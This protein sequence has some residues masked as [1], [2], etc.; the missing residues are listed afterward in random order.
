M[1]EG[2]RKPNRVTRKKN[3]GFGQYIYPGRWNA[4]AM[5]MQIQRLNELCAETNQVGFIGRLETDGAPVLEGAF[6]RLKL[7]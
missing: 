6:V 7:A 1:L 2:C 3:W 5:G 4:D